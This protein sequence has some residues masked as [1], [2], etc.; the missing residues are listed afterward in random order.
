MRRRVLRP[1]VRSPRSP[2]L[3]RR[4][5]DA[6]QLPVRFA[7]ARPQ[8]APQ[9]PRC[10][11]GPGPPL[12]RTTPSAILRASA[13]AS[14]GRFPC[15]ARA[16]PR[17]LATRTAGRR[18]ASNETGAPFVRAP[19]TT[20]STARPD[21]ACLCRPTGAR[22]RC[23]ARVR[24]CPSWRAATSSA[25]WRAHRARGAPRER[26]R[27]ASA[28]RGARRGRSSTDAGAGRSFSDRT[29]D[30]RAST[31]PRS[32]LSRSASTEAPVRPTFAHRLTTARHRRQHGSTTARQ[33]KVRDRRMGRNGRNRARASA[34]TWP[35]P[36][37]IRISLGSRS[38]RQ[39]RAR[40]GP[41]ACRE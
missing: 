1:S 4:S 5:G 21:D 27:G 31:S 6:L 39:R 18:L 8:A 32:W 36:C 29:E 38:T 37:P 26:A 2:S 25:R 23:P 7:L 30:F 24:P 12:A 10:S 22:A 16:C 41:R 11:C 15:S 34:C 20:R 19:S 13:R 40:S 33:G 14:R 35:S 17:P 9:P 3:S 28:L